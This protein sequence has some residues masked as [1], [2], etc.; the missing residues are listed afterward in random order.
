MFKV[1]N[2]RDGRLRW[3]ERRLDLLAEAVGFDVS[4]VSSLEPVVAQIRL[5]ADIKAAELYSRAFASSLPEAMS[6]VAD[7]KARIGRA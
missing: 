1:R 4:E 3:L 5:G 2:D 7:L 6:A